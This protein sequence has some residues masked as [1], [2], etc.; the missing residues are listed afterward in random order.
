MSELH[1][2]ERVLPYDVITPLFT[3]YAKKKKFVWMPEGTSAIYASD[4]NM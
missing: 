4:N 1:P 3:D 2:N